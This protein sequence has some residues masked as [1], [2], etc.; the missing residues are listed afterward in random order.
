MTFICLLIQNTIRGDKPTPETSYIYSK[1]AQILQIKREVDGVMDLNSYCDSLSVELTGW[2]EKVDNIVSKLDKMASGDK[3][4]VVPHVNEL[5]GLI[6][7]L[8]DRIERLKKECPTEWS[9]DK[10]ELDSKLS[11]ITNIWESVWQNVSG[12]DVGG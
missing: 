11:R 4:K 6:E 2:K 5:H 9:P 12:A 10:I 3:E 8:N 1:G 7:E